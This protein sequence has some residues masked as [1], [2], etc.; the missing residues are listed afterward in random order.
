MCVNE[1]V[2]I[3]RYASVISGRS[4]ELAEGVDSAASSDLR[5][6]SQLEYSFHDDDDKKGSP[7]PTVNWSSRH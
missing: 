6:R 3:L 2:P 5:K 4:R 1:T 7:R